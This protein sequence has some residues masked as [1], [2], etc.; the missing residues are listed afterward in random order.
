M[1]NK[2][3]LTGVVDSPSHAHFS[4]FAHFCSVDEEMESKFGQMFII[5][6]FITSKRK[7]LLG[8]VDTPSHAHFFLFSLFSLCYNENSNFT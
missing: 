2:K 6:A 3:I 4:V 5:Q 8:A 1:L 7:F